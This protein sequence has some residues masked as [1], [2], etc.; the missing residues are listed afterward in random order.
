[1]KLQKISGA[2]HHSSILPRITIA[3]SFLHPINPAYLHRTSI[4]FFIIKPQFPPQLSPPLPITSLQQQPHYSNQPPFEPSSL[5]ETTITTTS[6]TISISLQPNHLHT[7]LTV[8][9]T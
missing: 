4:I 9:H 7:F 2:H 3:A 6:F 8:I 1:M 5:P